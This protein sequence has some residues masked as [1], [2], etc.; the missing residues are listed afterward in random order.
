MSEMAVDYLFVGIILDF[1]LSTL[2]MILAL[3]EREFPNSIIYHFFATIGYI[4][5]AQLFL[6]AY[7]T[8][9]TYVIPLHYLFYMFGATNFILFLA[10]GVSALSAYAYRR[11]FGHNKGE[12]E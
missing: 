1:C 11:K 12:E 2:F 6:M 7:S 9:A 4:F 5:L 8:T 3:E 10:W